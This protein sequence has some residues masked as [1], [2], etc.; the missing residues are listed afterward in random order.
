MPYYP[1][2]YLRRCL[3]REVI[4]KFDEHWTVIGPTTHL[5]TIK[6][7]FESWDK[8]LIKHRHSDV[9][10]ARLRMGHSRLRGHMFRIGLNDSPNC[11][12]CPLIETPA[13]VLLYCP[14]YAV[15]RATLITSLSNLNITSLSLRVL[16]GGGGLSPSQTVFI[17]HAVCTFLKKIKRYDDI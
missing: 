3:L 8:F 9:V 10:I 11:P 15:E 13:H 7:K 16:L 6:D 12:T 14:A 17:F 5:G 4:S 2:S 1:S